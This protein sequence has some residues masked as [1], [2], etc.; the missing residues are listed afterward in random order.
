[1]TDKNSVKDWMMT[2]TGRQVWPLHMT[3]DDVNIDDIAHSLALQCRFNGMVSDFY[4]VAEHCLLISQWLEA[5]GYDVQTQ[6]TGLLHDANEAYLS[7]M[8][9]PIKNALGPAYEPFRKAGA[10]ID[11][12][13]ARKYGSTHPF[14]HAV[15]EADSRIINDEKQFL[16]GTG[17]PWI[18]GGSP[19]GVEIKCLDPRQ[20]ERM[21]RFRFYKLMGFKEA[22]PVGIGPDPDI[23][24]RGELGTV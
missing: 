7:D 22:G 20:A 15:H 8:I 21:Y 16:F 6:L 3:D 10:T 14:P 19:L 23:I 12:I 11:E 13:I 18:H 17:K 5:N 24:V 1:M 2:Y 4:S 9:R